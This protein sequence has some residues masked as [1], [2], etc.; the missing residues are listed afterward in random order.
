MSGAKLDVTKDF[1]WSTS[2][3]PVSNGRIDAVSANN[4]NSEL[5][6]ALPRACQPWGVRC[7]RR[8]KFKL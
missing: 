6:P 3:L 8:E 7:I 1:E 2:R 4:P 5:L